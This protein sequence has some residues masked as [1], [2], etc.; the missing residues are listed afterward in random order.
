MLRNIFLKTVRDYRRQILI[1]GGGFFLLMLYGLVYN[2]VFGPDVPNR[3]KVIEDYRKT[4]ESFT[5]ITGKVY[6]IGTF[7]GF[8]N[9][10]IGG[11]MGILMGIWALMAGSGLIR[12]E[13]ERGSMDVLLTTP[14]SRTAVLLQKW[15]AMVV[16]MFVISLCG[17]L[18]LTISAAGTKAD[19]SPWDGLMAHLNWA[20]VGLFIGGLAML[21]S[22]LTSRK[23]AAGWAGGIM[24]ATYL[25]ENLLQQNLEGL[26]WV[27]YFLPF[28]YSSLS[29][30]LAR[31]VGT[32]WLGISVLIIG[33]I[34]LAGLSLWMFLQRD[35]NSYFELFKSKKALVSS[36]FHRQA[37]PKK[38]W[39]SN[40]F[41]FALR[42]SLPGVLIWG[43]SISV[44]TLLI[45][46][47]FNEIKTDFLDLLGSNDIFKQLGFANLAS[48]ENILSL[49]IF[50]FV[51]LLAAAYAIVQVSSWTAEENEGRLELLLSTPQPRW[52]VLL[53]YFAVAVVSSALMIG[54][55]GVIFEVLTWIFNVTVSA[56]NTFAAFFGL[57][58][59]CVIIAAVGYVLAAFGPSWAV[60]V[61]AGLVVLSYFSDLLRD[62]LKLPDV[63]TNLS[64]FRQYGRPLS[65]GLQWT[66]Q[67]VMIVLSVV[68][69]TV[70]AIRF[71]QRDI[72][73]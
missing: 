9:T 49:F 32:N 58:I 14:H 54:L 72:N 8:V 61:T 60:G 24:A 71:W 57:W 28:Y 48:N 53:T 27:R 6:D 55:V 73:K 25:L 39:L 12:T 43:L 47:V 2:T 29:Q 44:W 46:S 66:P 69:I 5:V 50:L 65:E 1:W 18:G 23:A 30:P 21:F 37:E 22:Q 10:K 41:T 40:N 34:V 62:V 16:T 13:E 15:A 52:R 63:I 33:I 45:M 67:L 17:W 36:K 56:G 35:L 59:V 7:G 20:L 3:A 42:A 4:V 11:T 31:S 64:V 51:V 38:T 70:A 26:H 68:F 19:L